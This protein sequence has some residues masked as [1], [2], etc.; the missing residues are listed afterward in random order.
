MLHVKRKSIMKNSALIKELRSL[1]GKGA[2]Q[3]VTDGMTCGIGTGST[4]TFLI[5]ELGRRVREEGLKFTAVPTSFQTRLL[6]QQ[7]LIPVKSLLDCTEVDLAIDSADEVDQAFN[8]IKGDGAVQT[9]EK[10]VAAMAKQVIL[11]IDESKLVTEL[12]K[13][14]PVPVE[15]IPD[16]LCL[17]TEVITKLGG[18]VQLRMGL[19][20]EGPVITDNKQFL[21][22]AGFKCGTDLRMVDRILH[23]TP[24]VVETGLFF[25]LATMA[26]VG[27]AAPF[28]VK[29]LKK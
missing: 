27:S 11:I 6:C 28:R 4:V 9:R 7:N 29:T 22:D 25:D 26:L 3:R 18:E 12:G 23:Q 17:V 13:A 2:A 1:V 16:A 21:L 10:I 8:A 15:I 20:K 5:A 19:C 14:C 24:G